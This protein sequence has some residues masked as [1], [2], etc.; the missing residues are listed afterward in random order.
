MPEYF[1]Q[2]FVTVAESHEQKDKQVKTQMWNIFT[3]LEPSR[4]KRIFCLL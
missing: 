4:S 1:Q 3:M 2:Y